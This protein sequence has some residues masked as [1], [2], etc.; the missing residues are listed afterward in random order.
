MFSGLADIKIFIYSSIKM[1]NLS[2]KGHGMAWGQS[3]RVF[4]RKVGYSLGRLPIYG[5]ANTETNNHSYS[6]SQ[7]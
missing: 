6:H 1:Y 3:Q 5:R 2:M 7:P 4:E